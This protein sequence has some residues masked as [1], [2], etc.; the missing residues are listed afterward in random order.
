MR[1]LQYYVKLW[2]THN[3]FFSVNKAPHLLLQLCTKLLVE[4]LIYLFVKIG[5]FG[6][7]YILIYDFGR[8]ATQCIFTKSCMHNKS[9]SKVYFV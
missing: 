5:K 6:V 1:W 7:P 2:V 9:S 8:D 3:Y 4:L